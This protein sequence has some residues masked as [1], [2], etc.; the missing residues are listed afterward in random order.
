MIE[1]DIEK[2]IYFSKIGAIF[3]TASLFLIG[4][5]FF[6]AYA[7]FL[8]LPNYQ[9]G[10]VSSFAITVN[11]SNLLSLWLVERLNARKKLV[12]FSTFL[13][14]LFLI[15]LLFLSFID[16]QDV[17]LVAIILVVTTSNFFMA[18]A[19]PAFGSWLVDLIPDSIRGKYFGIRNMLAGL[20]G[21]IFI[22]LAGRF[23]DMWP[24]DSPYGFIILFSVA[25][26]FGFINAIMISKMPEITPKSN[27]NSVRDQKSYGMNVKTKIDFIE[28]VRAPFTNKIF[29]NL[30]IFR[31]FLQFS[32]VIVGVFISVYLL[33]ELKWDYSTVA[34]FGVIGNIFL[35]L[36]QKWWGIVSDKLSNKPIIYIGLVGITLLPLVFLITESV[37]FYI[38]AV[39]L[40]S[41]GWAAITIG[42]TNI[43]FRTAK[44]EHSI[45]Y[46]S[47]YSVLISL[48]QAF[49]TLIGSLII[50][51]ISFKVLFIISFVLR[52]L[53]F[54]FVKNI[55]EPQKTD[56]MGAVI[57]F[58][59]AIISDIIEGGHHL[60]H[61]VLLPVEIIK[62][63]GFHI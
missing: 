14:N 7:I 2:G 21:V 29:K 50:N 39:A 26:I 49:G 12:V 43:L 38:I 10:L 30:I 9:I 15:P 28:L 32:T 24:K 3:G 25:I 63:K 41:L 22:M 5:L 8:G 16:F 20:I 19:N 23:L 35:F 58:R 42:E 44:G 47:I 53:S 51:F 60:I 36:P 34:L 61:Y 45:S 62:K 46:I 56:I 1:K 33:R 11:I 27:V 18:I 54:L 13:A 59:K 40:C 52:L 17:R 57:I 48:S 37:V 4:D 6:T 31:C 55:Y